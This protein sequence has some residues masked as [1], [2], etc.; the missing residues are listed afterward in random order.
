MSLTAAV[1]DTTMIRADG[2]SPDTWIESLGAKT[3]VIAQ[4]QWS[5]TSC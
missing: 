2:M 3:K 1:F 5:L 4:L